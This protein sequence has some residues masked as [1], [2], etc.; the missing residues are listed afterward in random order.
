MT[1]ETLEKLP[2]LVCDFEYESL[3][4][5]REN[6][7]FQTAVLKE[8]LRVSH[9]VVSPLPRVV[10]PD[11]AV[12]GG[13]HVPAGVT[14]LTV[15]LAPFILIDCGGQTTVSIASTFLH[16]NTELFPNPHEFNPDRWLQAN[17]RELE[18][19]LVPFSRGP[20]SCLGIK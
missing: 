6:Q 3:P 20:R 18:N 7:T 9:G 16:N 8:S 17:S 1:Y 15:F 13:W 19:Y 4:R 12:I 14:I 11:S 2:Y 10:G 5:L